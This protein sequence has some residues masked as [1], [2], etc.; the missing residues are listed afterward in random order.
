MNNIW[1]V[2]LVKNYIWE[3]L[4]KNANTNLKYYEHDSKMHAGQLETKL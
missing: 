3:K 4:N 2:P 1:S